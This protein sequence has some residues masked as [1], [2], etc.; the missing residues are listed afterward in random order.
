MSYS[1]EVH[2]HHM[3]AWPIP[4]HI[5]YIMFSSSS[6]SFIL[7]WSTYD[8]SSHRRDENEDDETTN[9][10]TKRTKTKTTIRKWRGQ[11][12]VLLDPLEIPYF[13][14][15]FSHADGDEAD[16]RSTTKTTKMKTTMRKYERK[17]DGISKPFRTIRKWQG[18]TMLFLDPLELPRRRRGWRRRRRRTRWRRR[19]R[20]RRR[21]EN[22][23]DRRWY[24]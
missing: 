18:Q 2:N 19:R 6:S 22:D 15:V 23:E 9:T 21:S 8:S 1:Y 20:R 14:R 7:Y 16:K 10:V 13:P 12:M 4:S 11:T 3:K 5:L 17:H 24:F